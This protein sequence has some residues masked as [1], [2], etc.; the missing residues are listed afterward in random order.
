MCFFGSLVANANC[1]N[2]SVLIFRC[3]GRV[4]RWTARREHF[5]KAFLTW[6]S[7]V[8]T[9]ILSTEM[10]FLSL[11]AFFCLLFLSHSHLVWYENYT[12]KKKKIFKVK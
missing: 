8:D 7:H 1:N 11:H 3:G 2:R 10:H 9:E 4:A 5:N 6:S 12:E